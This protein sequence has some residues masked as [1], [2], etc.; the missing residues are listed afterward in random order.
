GVSLTDQVVA[1]G[2]GRVTADRVRDALG[3]VAEDEFIAMLDIIA[4]RR[5]ADVFPAVAKLGEAGVDF[6]GGLTGLADILRAQLAVVLGGAAPDVSD[7]GREALLQRRDRFTAADLLRMLQAITELEPRFRKSGQQQLLVETL[8]VRFAL[9][10]RAVEI[11]DLLR[12]M[13][14][15]SSQPS[16]SARD[17][18]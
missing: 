11:E 4:D 7:R 2:E 5:A 16:T 12:S 3:L 1:M 17:T 8:L 10:D 9:L 6:G 18:G 14:G 13:G 15:S